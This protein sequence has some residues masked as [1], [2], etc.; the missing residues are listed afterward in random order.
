MDNNFSSIVT[1]IKYGRNVIDNLRKFLQFQLVINLTVCS[2]IVIC[3]CIGSETP[4]KSIQMLWIDLIMDA[5]AT[6]TLASEPPHDGLL[7][8]KPTKRNE[9][10]IN[11]TMISHVFSQTAFQ[12]LILMMI[13]LYG[14]KY[15]QE[16]DL[17]RIAEN[18]IILECFG[19]LLGGEYEP[20]NIIYGIK[21][22]WPNYVKLN[23]NLSGR[24]ICGDY[25]NYDNLSKAY[26]LYNKRQG[27][28]VQLTMVFNI[29]VLYTLF[30]QINCRIVDGTLNIFVRILNNKL[31]I[32]IE[33]FEFLMQFII[34]E[35]W[36]IIF[37]TTK[38][39]LT[40]Y[41][42]GICI[43]ISSM[44]LLLDFILKIEYNSLFK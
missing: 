40:I 32:L 24:G 1:A 10:I 15:I 44:S 13:Y 30:N 5:L 39:G 34:I 23:E 21:T 16:Q 33:V 2:F 29:F 35:F 7:K 8:R 4:I 26:Y 28:P 42:W 22:Y 17:S 43:F 37:K 3:S 6:L 14:P 31:F 19:T 12:F 11:F 20:N 9:N 27:T 36:N 25:S 38:N 18:K 41:Q